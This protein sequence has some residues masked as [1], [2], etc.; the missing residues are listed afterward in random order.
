VG[1]WSSHCDEAK[2]K[3]SQDVKRRR[4]QAPVHD[5]Q[6]GGVRDIVQNDPGGCK[7]EQIIQ[8]NTR[9]HGRLA[10]TNLV[11]QRAAPRI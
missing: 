2:N 10:M 9:S 11:Y 6:P 1:T 7:P 8:K 4:V 3:R 5:M